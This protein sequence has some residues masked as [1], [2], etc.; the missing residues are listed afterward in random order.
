VPR[1]RPYSGAPADRP[2]RGG[3]L[4]RSDRRGRPQRSSPD[5][6][7]ARAAVDRPIVPWSERH[8]SLT[9][10]GSADRRMEFARSLIVPRALRGGP[11]RRAPLRIVHQALAGKERLL[12][13]G[14]GELLSTVTTGQSAILV[15]ALQ[16]LLRWDAVDGPAR[17]PRGTASGARGRRG[18]CAPGPVRAEPGSSREDT[19]AVKGFWPICQV[20]CGTDSAESASGCHA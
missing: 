2:L 9:P 4:I 5:L 17:G 13:C 7:E 16:T 18:D 19:R 1:S 11:T 14:E 15:H 20:R 12:A 6:V 3:G 8:D 10:A